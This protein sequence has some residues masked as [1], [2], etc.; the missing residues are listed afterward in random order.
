MGVKRSVREAFALVLA[1]EPT[2][3]ESYVINLVAGTSAVQFHPR[4]VRLLPFSVQVASNS[5]RQPIYRVVE[6]KRL[7]ATEFRNLI[8]QSTETD[9]GHFYEAGNIHKLQCAQNSL[10]RVALPHHPGTAS[11][12]LSHFHWLPVHRRI[13]YKIAHLTYKSFVNQPAIIPQKFVTCRPT[14]HRVVSA[15]PVKISYLFLSV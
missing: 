5:I 11:S 14:N 15:Q 12:R 6:W 2:F 13:Q 3:A 9:V 4:L 1:E 8:N 10:S 7:K